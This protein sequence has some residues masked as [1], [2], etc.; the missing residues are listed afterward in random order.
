MEIAFSGVQP[1]LTR[2]STPTNNG[3]VVPDKVPSASL[4]VPWVTVISRSSQ[5]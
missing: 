5:G 4:A 3:R 1:H 2:F